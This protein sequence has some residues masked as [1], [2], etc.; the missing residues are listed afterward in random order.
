MRPVSIEPD[1]KDWTWVLGATCGECG[2]DASALSRTDLPTAIEDNAEFRW[3][4][5]QGAQMS[6]DANNVSA[7]PEVPTRPGVLRRALR[8][9]EA[10]K[11]QSGNSD[12]TDLT[13][14]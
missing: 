10:G 3:H 9:E 2:F 8:T 11:I 5:K 1:V 12:Q 6:D 14:S 4:S 13:E 7:Q